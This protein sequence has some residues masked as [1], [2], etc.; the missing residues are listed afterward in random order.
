MFTVHT[1]LVFKASA[2]KTDA[3][4]AWN[5]V[6]PLRPCSH[7]LRASTPLHDR[8]KVNAGEV[9]SR[10]AEAMITVAR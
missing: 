9:H 10:A 4:C 3:Q 8:D 5:P 6:G 7:T 2:E 1:R